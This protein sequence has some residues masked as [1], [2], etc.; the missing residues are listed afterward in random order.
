MSSPASPSDGRPSLN[1]TRRRPSLVATPSPAS[2]NDDHPKPLCIDLRLQPPRSASLSNAGPT[3][4]HCQ[5]SI[6]SEGQ[7]IST[8]WCSLLNLVMSQPECQEMKM[9][10]Q[11]VTCSGACAFPPKL[12]FQPHSFHVVHRPVQLKYLPLCVLVKLDRTRIADGTGGMYDSRG[13]CNPALSH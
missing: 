7:S 13:T 9:P 2:S 6:K 1:P 10:L 12:R 4:T 11:G 8:C 3:L 5:L